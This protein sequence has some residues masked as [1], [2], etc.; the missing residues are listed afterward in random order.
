MANWRTLDKKIPGNG[1]LCEVGQL[2][3]VGILVP[4]CLGD[5]LG[6]LHGGDGRRQP[7]VGAEHVDARLRQT[8]RLP[9]DLLGVLLQLR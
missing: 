6:E 7:A 2:L 4:H 3:Q 8:D 9:D 5:H 1:L